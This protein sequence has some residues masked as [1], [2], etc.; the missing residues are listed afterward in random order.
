MRIVLRGGRVCDP[1]TG[2]EAIADVLVVDGRVAGV[3]PS[4]EA[5]DAETVDVTG[6]VIGPGFVDLHSH[7]HSILGHRVHAFDGVTTAL[8][9]EA[10]LS[11]VARAYQLAA[12]EGR[13]LNYGF[14]ASWTTARGL[15]HLGLEPTADFAQLHHLLGDPEW[16]RDSSPRE[17][18]AWVRFLDAEVSAGALGIGILIGYAP[19]SDPG[20]FLRVA[21]LAASAGAPT[22]THVREIVEA[23]P[24]TPIDGSEEIVRAAGETGAAMHHCHVNSTSRR[25]IDRVLAMIERAR[26]EGSRVTVEAYPWGAGKTSI[27]AAFL[28]PDRLG[29]W[30]MVPSDISVL[31]TGERVADA[32]RLREIRAVAPETPVVIEYL[33]EHDPADFALIEA[34]FAFPDAIPA[35]DGTT[36]AWDRA[37][38]PLTWPLP[39]G[40][41][42]HPRV[43]GT[44]TKAI[45]IM[46]RTETWS[47]LEV[48]RRCAYLPS[49]ILDGIAPAMTRKGHL[50]VGADADIVVLDPARVGERA[51]YAEPTLLASGVRHLLVG[52]EFVIR[53]AELRVDAFPGRPVRGLPV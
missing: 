38:D 25:H 3:E 17:R 2:S 52:G 14:S 43:A 26:V 49:R 42:A 18:S 39:P 46:R 35:S 13:P 6:C 53:D 36:P 31:L 33:H 11:P 19:R 22:F 10:G 29:A 12:D 20:D 15:A 44:F 41:R 4:V 21:A 45:R 23:D 9:L 1:G 27:G 7:T 50:T 32:A 47:W 8:D 28:A 30:G 48:F 37:V 24:T 34:A 51:T 40:G 16:Q 5:P